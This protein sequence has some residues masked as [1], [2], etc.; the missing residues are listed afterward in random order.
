MLGD[1]SYMFKYFAIDSASNTTLLN[2]ISS[3]Q[4][5][6]EVV[7]A[8]SLSNVYAEY[9]INLIISINKEIIIVNHIDGNILKN[10]IRGAFNTS[11]TSH[12]INDVV[13]DK[14]FS[15]EIY[16]NTLGKINFIKYPLFNDISTT[17]ENSV[18]PE[19][20][21]LKQFNGFI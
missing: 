2:D 9:G 14:G 6:I 3:T 13:V 18:N 7:N 8:S 17:L 11:S 1:G 10:C 15:K 5:D 20:I 16:T 21:A 19:S 12:T 4:T